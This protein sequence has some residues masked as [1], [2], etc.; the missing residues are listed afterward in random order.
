MKSPCNGNCKLNEYKICRGCYRSLNEIKL[1]KYMS[2]E[3]QKVVWDRLEK[4]SE[5]PLDLSEG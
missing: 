4:K 5:K 2:E 3:E 1:W